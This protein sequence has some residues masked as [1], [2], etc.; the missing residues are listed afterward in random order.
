PFLFLIVVGRDP[1]SGPQNDPCRHE[2][3]CTV[4]CLASIESVV[5]GRRLLP[6]SRTNGRGGF[7]TGTGFLLRGSHLEHGSKPDESSPP[8]S[9]WSTRK[10][11]PTWPLSAQEWTPRLPNEERE[12]SERLWSVVEA[13]RRRVSRRHGVDPGGRPLLRTWSHLR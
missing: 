1:A 9:G 12:Q 10:A 5:T 13:L 7:V 8:G 4:H 11:I 6:R 2:Q 3:C